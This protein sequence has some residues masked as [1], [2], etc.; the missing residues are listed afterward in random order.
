M[1]DINETAELIEAIKTQTKEMRVMNY[2]FVLD[3]LHAWDDNYSEED[4]CRDLRSLRNLYI[5]N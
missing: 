1:S 4:Y 2:M 3:R 5:K